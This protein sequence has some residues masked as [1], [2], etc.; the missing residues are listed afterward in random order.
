MLFRSITAP[1]QVVLINPQGVYFG[2]TATVDVGGLVATTHNS[3]NQAF[4]DGQMKFDRQGSSAKVV[5]EGEL[6]AALGG[7]IALLAPEVRNQGVI[8]AQMGT[9]A[10]AAGEAHHAVRD[11]RALIDGRCIDIVQPSIPGVGGITEAKRIVA[12]AHAQNLRVAPHVW[13]GAVGLATA[14]HFLAALPATP[15]TEH[16]PHPSMLE[17]DMSDNELRTKLLKTPLKLED[18]HV[19]LPDGPG[20]GIELDW[21]AVERYRVC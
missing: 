7:Y 18:G 1:G 8:V 2:K 10:L 17:Y 4:M 14:S 20:L 11:F 19:L 13:G 16:P 5:N 9:V 3:A 21:D 6:K 15:H 12:L